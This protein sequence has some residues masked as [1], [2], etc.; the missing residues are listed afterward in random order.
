M[1]K[2]ISIFG[3][4]AL[5]LA[6]GVVIGQVGKADTPAQPGSADDPIVTKSY[7]DAKLAGGGGTNNGGGS[8]GSDAFAVVQLAAGQVLKGSAGTEIILRSGSATAVSSVN[9]AVVDVSGS[10]DLAQDAKVAINHL[11]LIPRTDGR[12]VKAGSSTNFFMVRGAYTIE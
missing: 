9:G 3:T 12:G 7:V 4:M 2:S 6:I 5:T 8:T 1:K 11:L 10:A